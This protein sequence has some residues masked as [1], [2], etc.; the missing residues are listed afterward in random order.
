MAPLSPSQ[1]SPYPKPPFFWFLYYSAISTTCSLASL[2]L[3][4]FSLP[5]WS[6]LL[7]SSSLTIW[8]A[9][10]PGSVCWSYLVYYFLLLLWTPPDASECSFPRIYNRNLLNISWSG[11]VLIVT[12]PS[13]FFFVCFL[14]KSE[15]VC[16]TIWWP[17]NGSVLS[18]SDPWCKVPNLYYTNS[19]F[20][21]VGPP[22]AGL[23]RD[24]QMEREHQ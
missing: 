12:Q 15:T 9:S 23:R 8:S 7:S 11:Y 18:V 22:S 3:S 10:Q 21:G 4:W 17:C 19:R 13:S 2:S 14:F 5:S 1:H 16:S 6:S 20:L 24:T